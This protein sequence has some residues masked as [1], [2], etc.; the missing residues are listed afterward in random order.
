VHLL[1]TWSSTLNPMQQWES[2]EPEAA[3]ADA[4]PQKGM[5]WIEGGY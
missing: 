2:L 3:L 1:P 4:F 5:P